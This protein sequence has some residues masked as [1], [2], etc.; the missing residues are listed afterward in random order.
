[1]VISSGQKFLF[2]KVCMLDTGMLR[3][4]FK[5]ASFHN[6]VYHIHSIYFCFICFKTTCLCSDILGAM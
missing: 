3:I 4:S 1:M 5:F 2:E 6:Y